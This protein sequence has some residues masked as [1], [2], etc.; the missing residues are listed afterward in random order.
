MHACNS[1]ARVRDIRVSRACW[2]PVHSRFS[3]SPCLG[4]IRQRVIAQDTWHPPL[5]STYKCIFIHPTYSRPIHL[6]TYTHIYMYA[7]VH[8]HILVHANTL[9]HEY[10]C[11]CADLHILI[12]THAYLHTHTHPCMYMDTYKH[13]HTCVCPCTYMPMQTHTYMYTH[14]HIY[15]YAQANSYWHTHAPAH[16]H[17]H[18]HTHT[19]IHIHTHTRICTHKYTSIHAWTCTHTC[20]QIWWGVCVKLWTW[21]TPVHSVLWYRLY[22]LSCK[23]FW[24]Q[25]RRGWLEFCCFR[26]FI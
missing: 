19:F 11:T 20:T 6:H 5:T 8:M 21:S 25:R 24:W 16:T 7:H 18:M 9:M 26:N 13:I 23:T 17:S 22:A 10:A 3:E 1:C 15:A 12:Y 14:S 2:T 4:E